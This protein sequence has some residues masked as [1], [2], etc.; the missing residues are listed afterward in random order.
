LGKR[1]ALGPG[2]ILTLLYVY[3]PHFQK[4]EAHLLAARSIVFIK[5][6]QKEELK[7]VPGAYPHTRDEVTALQM[8]RSLSFEDCKN[9]YPHIRLAKTE[10]ARSIVDAYLGRNR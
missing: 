7:A 1:Q 3:H 4:E 2:D 8:V 6:L 5:L 9:L 10:D